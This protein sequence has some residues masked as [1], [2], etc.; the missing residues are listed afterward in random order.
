M[1]EM[2]G[3]GSN[4]KGGPTTS[5]LDENGGESSLEDGSSTRLSN[6]KE[7]IS[8][9]SPSGIETGPHECG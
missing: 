3:L 5:R 1:G 4:E 7:R 8:R 9:V 2:N 6:L